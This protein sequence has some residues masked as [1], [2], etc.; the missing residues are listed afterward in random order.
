M[1]KT[2]LHHVD[3]VL[4]ECGYFPTG[5]SFETSCG[6]SGR[7]SG[8]ARMSSRLI[9]SY[10]VLS[11]S[12]IPRSPLKPGRQFDLRRGGQGRHLLRLF[13]RPSRRMR[14]SRIDIL[15]MVDRGTHDRLRRAFNTCRR[16][17]GVFK[18]DRCHLSSSPNCSVAAIADNAFVMPLHGTECGNFC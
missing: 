14:E 6:G 17:H 9:P 5:R 10:K 3:P 7:A 12:C 15:V 11:A 4:E 18:D 2:V 16:A 1:A 8:C 13:A